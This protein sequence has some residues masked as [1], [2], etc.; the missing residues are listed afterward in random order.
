MLK[1]LSDNKDGLSVILSIFA[2]IVSLLNLSKITMI[3]GKIKEIDLSEKEQ[4]KKAFDVRFEPKKI[5]DSK[6]HIRYV[7]ENKSKNFLK[8]ENKYHLPSGKNPCTLKEKMNPN[9][10]NPV[11]TLNGSA[12]KEKYTKALYAS[13]AMYIPP[14]SKRS[15]DYLIDVNAS[16][17]SLLEFCI[18][19]CSVE[20]EKGSCLE[21][22]YSQFYQVDFIGK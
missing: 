1:W 21:E 17:P 15:I 5:W 22:R 10:E 8:I 3:D 20:D 6:F 9:L 12:P 19:V 13:R 2:L 16:E 11:L 14:E 4:Q 18:E 7:I